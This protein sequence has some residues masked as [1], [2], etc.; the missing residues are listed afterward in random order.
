[1]NNNDMFAN[2]ILELYTRNGFGKVL[3]S[4]IDLTVFHHY[5]LENLNEK[6]LENG[7]IKYFNIDKSEIYRLSI[8]MKITESRFKRL[9]E[10]DYFL[11]S[12][13]VKVKK[14]LLYLNKYSNEIVK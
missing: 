9:L 14:F 13:T 3:K 11:Y 8:L 12:E 7:N 4:E 6:Y 1:M 10:E 2:K 5:L